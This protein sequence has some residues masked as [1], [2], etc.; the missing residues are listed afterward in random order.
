MICF[1]RLIM[2]KLTVCVYRM[3]S[4][5][6]FAWYMVVEKIQKI[7]QI[8]NYKF[9]ELVFVEK[10]KFEIVGRLNVIRTNLQICH[11]E[12]HKM[13]T[14]KSSIKTTYFFFY[15]RETANSKHH[16]FSIINSKSINQWFFRP[17]FGLNTFEWAILCKNRQVLYFEIVKSTDAEYGDIAKTSIKHHNKRI[18]SGKEEPIKIKTKAKQ[19]QKCFND[20]QTNKN[21]R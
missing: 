15:F 8:E 21:I 6:S 10:Q 2:R 13:R 11:F 9:R 7:R 17:T 4:S 5:F 3:I 14:K 12:C 16:V 19:Q 20:K 1:L 18:F